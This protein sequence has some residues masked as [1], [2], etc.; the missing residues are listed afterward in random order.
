MTACTDF[1]CAC[2]F[3]KDDVGLFVKKRW[4]VVCV[5]MKMHKLLTF[6]H[7]TI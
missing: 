1:V 4:P 5:S 2:F 6:T 3:I 7:D